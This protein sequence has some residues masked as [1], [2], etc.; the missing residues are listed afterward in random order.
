MQMKRP[1]FTIEIAPYIG[2][3]PVPITYFDQIWEQNKEVGIFLAEA[4]LGT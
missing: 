2:P 3:R 1:S 4:C